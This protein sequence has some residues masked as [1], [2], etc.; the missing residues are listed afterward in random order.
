MPDGRSRSSSTAAR[1]FSSALSTSSR[2]R[3][4]SLV[5]ALARQ[6]QV[7]QQRRRA[8]AGRR[9]AGRGRAGGARRRRPRRCARATRAAPAAARAARPR[10]GRSRAR[11][12]RRP[13]AARS[14]SGSSLQRGVV[15]ERA[16]PAALVGDLGGDRAAPAGAAR[17]P[18]AVDVAAP[19]RQPVRDGE[20][21]I[22]ERGRERVAR[23]RRA[24]AEREPLDQPRDR[25]GAEEAA[26]REPDEERDRQRGEARDE[27]ELGRLLD[28]V[29]QVERLRGRPRRAP[30]RAGPP[31]PAASGANARRWTSR[32]AHG[33][34]TSDGGEREAEH[35]R[36][37]LRRLGEPVVGGDEEGLRGQSPQPGSPAVSPNSTAITCGHE[38]G[39][40]ARRRPP[41]ATPAL[42]PPGRE[43]QQQVDEERQRQRVGD[44]RDDVRQRRVGDHE[45]AE[46]RPPGRTPPSASPSRCPAGAAAYAPRPAKPQPT[47]TASTGTARP[48]GGSRSR[49][50][51]APASATPSA[52]AGDA[53]RAPRR[54]A[55][56]VAIA[57]I[58]GEPMRTR[59]WWS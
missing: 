24:A 13:A 22:A 39:R 47:T 11:A 9:R 6:L 10:G 36:R 2:E 16:D 26:A 41:S 50:A 17:R 25:R 3:S 59:A 34:A 54:A 29:G 12:P 27:D 51:S 42:Q 52:T 1:A 37:R 49:P 40:V 31:R 53:A 30:A 20:R 15:D 45:P 35:E 55:R 56:L 33:S 19:L 44:A 5:P 8:A 38:R 4:G 18:V 28:A 58:A 23:R 21:G 46:Q 32:R 7:D 48:P 43:R 14:S 57:A